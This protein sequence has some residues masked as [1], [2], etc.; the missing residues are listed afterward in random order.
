MMCETSGGTAAAAAAVDD[1]DGCESCQS[2]NPKYN[3]S[4]RNVREFDNTII[5][6]RTR[7]YSNFM[8]L[9]R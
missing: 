6:T 4:N 7:M 2:K 9:K 8:K 1:T 5:H 3:H